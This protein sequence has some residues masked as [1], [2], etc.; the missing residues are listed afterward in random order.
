MVKKSIR[1]K[2]VYRF[3]ATP[4]KT[5][6]T[7]FTSKETSMLKF[8]LGHKF[9]PEHEW[10]WRCYTFQFWI[11]FYKLLNHSSA[12]LTLKTALLVRGMDWINHKQ[13]HMNMVNW[14][15]TE[16]VRTY[17]GAESGI[18]STWSWEPRTFMGKNEIR[19]VPYNT[20]KTQLKMH[21]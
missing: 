10:A 17:F 21:L 20:W 13:I 11:I 6:M 3:K 19:L 1:Q 7:F 16:M 9:I 15:L 18:V 5:I 12:V 14:F 2:Y 4:I 8:V